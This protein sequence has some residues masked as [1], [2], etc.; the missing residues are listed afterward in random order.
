MM[1]LSHA[2]ITMIA[3][4]IRPGEAVTVREVMSRLAVHY[5]SSVVRTVLAAMARDGQAIVEEDFSDPRFLSKRYRLR[6]PIG[7]TAP[8]V[9]RELSPMTRERAEELTR[10]AL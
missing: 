7:V 2:T 4:A 8:L 6:E 5:S 1:R 9:Y 3:T 10:R